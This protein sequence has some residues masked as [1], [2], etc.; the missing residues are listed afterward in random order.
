MGLRITGD[1]LGMADHNDT[2]VTFLWH[3]AGT[4][5]PCIDHHDK[6]INISITL[7]D[8]AGVEGV[9]K[10]LRYLNRIEATKTAVSGFFLFSGYD[11]HK[12]LV[13]RENQSCLLVQRE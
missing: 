13:L 10:Q 12:Q 4:R 7:A 9:H 6:E 11:G 8:I 3:V 5:L 1:L 2:G